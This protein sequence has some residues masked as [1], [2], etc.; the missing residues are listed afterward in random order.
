MDSTN[1]E[2]NVH[3]ACD[4]EDGES[5]EEESTTVGS[6]FQGITQSLQDLK[7]HMISVIIE[8]VVQGFRMLS[9]LYKKEK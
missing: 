7:E 6:V 9:K 8:H 3:A 4:A 2:S 1:C 5:Q